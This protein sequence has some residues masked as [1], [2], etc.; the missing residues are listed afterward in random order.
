M[1]KKIIFNICALLLIF[2]IFELWCYFDIN[3]HR[4]GHLTA[5]FPKKKDIL[6]STG[7]YPLDRF[8][9]NENHIKYSKPP[10]LLLGC[11]YTYGHMLDS[12]KDFATKLQIQSNR[13]IYNFGMIGQGPMAGLTLLEREE[14]NKTINEEPEY[15]I[16]TYMFQHIQRWCWWR[17]YNEYR[18]HNFIPFQKYNFFD[19]FYSV[20]YFRNR[21][22]DDY[23][24][25]DETLEKRIDLLLKMINSM[26]IQSKK[27]YPKSKFIVLLYSDINKDLCFDLAQD[28]ENEKYFNLLYSDK[29]KEKL[30]KLGLMV[31][32][33]EEL[34]GR[35][36]NKI[37]DR[38]PSQ[39]DVN[40]PH[41][42]ETAWNEI[43][44]KLIKRFNL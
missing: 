34:I 20:S 4:Y 13:H 44:P 17:Y 1:K 43:V 10:I 32:S 19:N 12:D 2:L 28:G 37:E 35:K 40:H 14:E 27:L 22:I 5:Y 41:P 21:Q 15:I 25:N 9:N 30:E 36:M 7:Y 38:I 6:A 31:V 42:S 26:N 8:K 11:S 33:T 18:K 3:I 29:F 39:I 23:F 16:Y 24:Y